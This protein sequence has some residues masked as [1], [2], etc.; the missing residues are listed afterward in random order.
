MANFTNTE[1]NKILKPHREE[2]RERFKKRKLAKKNAVKFPCPICCKKLSYSLES[3][4]AHMK[5]KHG[6]T[7]T[8]GEKYLLDTFDPKDYYPYYQE[9]PKSVKTISGGLPSLGKKR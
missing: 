9:K 8:S 6:R 4:T 7:P 3:L 2:M 5:D 1:L